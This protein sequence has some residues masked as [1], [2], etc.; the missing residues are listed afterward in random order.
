[1]RVRNERRRRRKISV[2]MLTSRVAA[3]LKIKRA[4]LKRAS[5]D[6]FP[7]RGRRRRDELLTRDLRSGG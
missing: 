7:R 4:Y 1:V 2:K 5:G 6:R 3:F